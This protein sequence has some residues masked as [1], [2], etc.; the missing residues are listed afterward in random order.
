MPAF[1]IHVN[2]RPSMCV[3]CADQFIMLRLIEWIPSLADSLLLAN[4]FLPFFGMDYFPDLTLLIFFF[5]CSIKI[6][7]HFSNSKS[8][9]IICRGMFFVFAIVTFTFSIFIARQDRIHRDDLIRG[10]TQ[11]EISIQNINARK[12]RELID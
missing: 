4:C 10:K 11:I 3:L 5:N 7:Q 2:N 1:I 9:Q 8:K 12:T 6:V